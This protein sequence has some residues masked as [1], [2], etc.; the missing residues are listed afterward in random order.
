MARAKLTAKNSS[1]LPKIVSNVG[2]RVKGV[3]VARLPLCVAFLARPLLVALALCLVPAAAR[4]APFD[5]SGADWEGYADFIHL[6]RTELGGPRVVVTNRLEWAALTPN[7]ALLVVF[8]EHGVDATSAGAFVRAGGRLALLD[9]FGAGD[10]LLGSFD[11]QRVPLPSRPV[12]ALRNNPDL[13]IAD[14]DADAQAL[15]QGVDRVVTNHATGLRQ[16]LLTTVLHVRGTDGADV[17]VALSASSGE[18]RLFALGDPSAVMNAMLRY[19]GNRALA[20]NLT[21]YLADGHA[22]GRLFVVIRTFTETGTFAGVGGPEHELLAALQRA[23]GSIARDGLP[24]WLL[25]WLSLVLGMAVLLWLIPRTTRIYRGAR[26]GS[27]DRPRSRRR[28][29]PP[30]TPPRW[31]PGRPTGGT[32][33]SSG[34]APCSRTSRR[35]SACPW[36]PR[37]PR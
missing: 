11:I 21:H 29:A 34:A 9:D 23:R 28:G 22:S 35:T 15:T 27:R 1:L 26:P 7:D 36:R 10:E 2:A 19:P 24:A 18:G 31:A 12:L 33:C 8:P 16:P 14:P 5:P 20:R 32:R 30:A 17:P 13:A 3:K 6:L 25:Y 4:A 37:A